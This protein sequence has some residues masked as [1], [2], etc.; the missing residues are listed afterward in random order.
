MP[1]IY[2]IE[3]LTELNVNEEIYFNK[4]LVLKSAT[5]EQQNIIKSL[6]SK[7]GSFPSE[8]SSYSGYHEYKMVERLPEGGI[9]SKKRKQE[10][11]RYFILEHNSNQINP[12]FTKALA[13]KEKE[14]FIPFGFAKADF[15]MSI[16][17]AISE[18]AAYTFYNDKNTVFPV[19]FP[20]DPKLFNNEDKQEFEL[21]MSLLENFDLKKEKYPHINKALEDFLKIGEISNNSVFKI[22]S[23]FACLEL[24]IVDNSYDKLKSINLQLQSK[25][26]LLNNRFGEKID[27]SKYIKGPDTLTLGKVIGIIYDYRSSIAHGDFLNFEKKLQVLEKIS[28]LEITNFLRV[29]VKKV[30]VYSLREPQLITD[31][32]KC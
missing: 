26:N 11:F 30:V 31:L 19:K 17:H 27:I 25:L 3:D 24:L 15:G 13:L 28:S 29:V 2:Y 14:F 16:F 21:N 18:L 1:A 32:K 20:E 7:F 22:V 5:I 23:Y 9:K 6:M 8:P 10:D 12:F 4:D